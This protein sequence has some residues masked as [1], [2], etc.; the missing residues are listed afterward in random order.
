MHSIAGKNETTYAAHQSQPARGEKRQEPSPYPRVLAVP[1]RDLFSDASR[2]LEYFWGVED[3]RTQRQES[4]NGKKGSAS[5]V[6]VVDGMREN[7][8]GDV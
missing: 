5:V 6:E 2:Q 4:E 8:E 1:F 3:S 7:E